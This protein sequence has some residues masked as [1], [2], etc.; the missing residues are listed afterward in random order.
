MRPA[1]IAPCSLLRAKSVNAVTAL[2]LLAYPL[3][4][5]LL[6]DRVSPALMAV[7]LGILAAARIAAGSSIHRKHRALLLILLGLFCTVAFLD[8]RREWVKLYPVLINGAGAGWFGWTLVHPPSAAE[9]LARVANPE[10]Q[11]DLRK[12][13]YTKRVTQI[14]VAFFLFSGGA[15][16]YTALAASTGAW[17]I[18]NGLIS[19]LLIGLLLG[20][21]YLFRILYRRRHYADME[22]CRDVTIS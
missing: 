18:Y 9:R 14:W 8:S 2:A 7:G 11:F 17:A 12:S 4:V 3:L 1:S 10:E 21:E 6:L 5:Y 22:T 16:T 13:V 15:A 20:G 19:Y